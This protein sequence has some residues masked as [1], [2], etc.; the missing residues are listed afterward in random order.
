MVN[1]FT[2]PTVND[3]R[4]L[5]SMMEF[6]NNTSSGGTFFPI[7]LLTIWVIAFIGS[8]FEGREAVRAWIFASFIAAVLA[9]PLAVTGLLDNNITYLIILLLSGG[10]FWIRLQNAPLA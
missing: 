7:M 5:F 6:I 9:I 1:N 8:L 3:T 10:I 2:L 4:D